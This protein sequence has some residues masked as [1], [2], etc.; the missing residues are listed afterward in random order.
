MIA[1]FSHVRHLSLR[2]V[3]F[4]NDD[5]GEQTTLDTTSSLSRLRAVELLSIA[6]F[7]VIEYAFMS[8]L[9]LLSVRSSD[10]NT[11]HVAQGIIRSSA[12]SINSIMWHSDRI[13]LDRMSVHLNIIPSF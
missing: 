11:L 10:S 8:Q 2:T 9:H 3:L 4:N 12:Q 1:S 13:L 5:V 7:P 6:Q